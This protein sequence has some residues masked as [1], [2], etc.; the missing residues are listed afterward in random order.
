MAALP[1]SGS[2]EAQVNV[3]TYHNDN[4]RTGVNAKETLLTPSNV[5]KNN[6]GKLFTQGVDGIVVG[7]PLY[8]S[9][10]SIP[11][12]SETNNVVY[13]ATHHDSVYAFDADNNAVINAQ[14]LLHWS[15][16]DPAAGIT[17]VPG[18]LQGGT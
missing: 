3:V 10:I 14:P 4:A 6:F 13:V 2:A 18:T 11:G 7:Q 9:N 15:F 8:L 17:I 1:L 12:G 16:I 5:N